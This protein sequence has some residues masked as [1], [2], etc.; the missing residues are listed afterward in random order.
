MVVHGG[1]VYGDKKATMDRWCKQY[2]ELPKNVKKYLVLEN[3]EKC[4]S[5][6]DCLDVSKRVN[7]PVVF[8]THH[9]ACYNLLHKDE[10][11]KPAE[12]YMSE[13]LESWK[14]RDIKPKF[15]VS[16][17]GSGQ[18]GHH[19]D[20][21]EVIPKYLLDIPAKYGVSIDIMIE[22]KLKEQAIFKLY[23]K[24]PILDCLDDDSIKLSK[25]ADKI[26]PENK[27]KKSEDQPSKDI[28]KTILAKRVKLSSENT[29]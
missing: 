18:C 19:S 6:E 14:R 3:C 1:G 4:F 16:E 5:I 21:I 20:L 25:K 28:K 15:H 17:Q 10:K 13:I 12:E 7:I 22:A 11:F 24:Y 9:Y 29:V 26:T 23:K 27:D 8:D 2:H